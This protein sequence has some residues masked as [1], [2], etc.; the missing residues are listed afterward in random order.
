M[1]FDWKSIVK[2]VAPLIGS[3]IPGP[4]DDILIKLASDALLGRDDG[5]D[6][7]IYVAA[8][9]MSPEQRS[10]LRKADNAYKV[11][12]AEIDLKQDKLHLEDRQSARELFS[13][14]IWPQIVL[15]ALYT[16]GYFTILIL[17]MMGKV[18]ME[19]SMQATFNII[20][21]VL[22]GAIPMILHFWFG[23]ST[24]SKEKTIKLGLK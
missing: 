18:Q 2:T 19:Y 4:I 10:A 5:T 20:L 23:S 17:M 14:N 24:G 3:V 13:I 12:M 6:E 1:K 21:G 8:M 11:K 15:S 22:T 7:E 9:G 16:I